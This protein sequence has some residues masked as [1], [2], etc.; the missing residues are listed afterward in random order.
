MATNPE[1]CGEGY[2]VGLPRDHPQDGDEALCNPID[3]SFTN[4]EETRKV[5]FLQE[6][7]DLVFQPFVHV[8]DVDGTNAEDFSIIFKEIIVIP[9]QNDK[10]LAQK[11]KKDKTMKET[12]SNSCNVGGHISR[13]GNTDS[14]KISLATNKLLS[15]NVYNIGPQRTMGII[16][17]HI[18][19]FT[20]EPF[21]SYAVEER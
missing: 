16:M 13:I 3:D 20:N 21:L 4:N 14:G 9:L 5:K 1:E 2:E 7:V 17:D 8:W 19:L 11:L 15:T 6:N 10:T 12:F 18:L